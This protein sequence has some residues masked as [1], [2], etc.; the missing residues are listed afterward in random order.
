MPFN[1]GFKALPGGEDLISIPEAVLETMSTDQRTSYTLVEAVKKG[2][3]PMGCKRYFVGLSAM[4]GLSQMQQL[5]A[6]I[7]IYDGQAYF[8]MWL[9]MKD[10]SIQQVQRQV[11]IQ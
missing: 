6:T 2:M 7:I 10:Q 4:P 11:H 8:N 3:L 9:Y 1:P 5:N